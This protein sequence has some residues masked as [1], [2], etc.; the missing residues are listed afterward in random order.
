MALLTEYALT[1]GIF[2]SSSYSTEEVAAIRL[3]SLK[4]VLLNQGLVRNLRNGEW[5]DTFQHDGNCLHFAG[6]EL[7]K[8]II[9]QNRLHNSPAVLVARPETED[10]WCREALASH[11]KNLANPLEG[12]IT[13][14]TAGDN[15]KEEKMVSAI[16]KLGSSSF[17]NPQNTTVRP[18]RTISDYI[19]HLRL[20]L[21]YSNSIMFIDPHL[22]PTKRH[23]RNF[24]KII[25]LICERK[26]MPLPLVEIHRVCYFGSGRNTEI[27]E[28][29]KLKNRFSTELGPMCIKAG[30]DMKVFVWDDFHDRCLISDLVGISMSNGF[31]ESNN[32]SELTTWTRLDR[33]GRDDLQRE[34][35]VASNQHVGRSFPLS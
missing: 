17:W 6:K 19:K 18:Y 8:K 35:D 13:T 2:N 22:D 28:L 30:L 7:L 34:F 14:A 25:E 5:R 10:D 3:S 1:P 29:E 27:I 33:S 9:K 11:N 16:D 23:Y 26:R 20:I 24:K 32:S 21:E 12:V 31:D 15:F 4:D